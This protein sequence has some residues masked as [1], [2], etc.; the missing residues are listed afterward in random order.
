MTDLYSVVA[1]APKIHLHCHLEGS[2][3]CSSSIPLSALDGRHAF[4]QRFGRNCFSLDSRQAFVNLAENFVSVAKVQ[5][6]RYGEI[7]IAPGVWAQLHPHLDVLDVIGAINQV[8]E[9]GAPD[10]VLRL[11]V[12][13]SRNLDVA[14]AM[15]SASIAVSARDRGVIGIGLG[16]AEVNA[17]VRRFRDTFSFA[18]KH[19]LHTVAHAGEHG[20]AESVKQAVLQ[21]GAER[22]GHA[23]SAIKDM[24]VVRLLRSRG[25]VVECCPTSNYLTQALP[26][27]EVHP[28][29]RLDQLGVRVVIDVDDPE[30]FGQTITDEYFS[31]ASS[32]GWEIMSRLIGNA[33]DGSFAPS[34]TKAKLW[35]ELKAYQD[36]V[37]GASTD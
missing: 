6:V 27:C 29:R 32:C 8:F 21:L 15:W 9:T 26:F 23:V 7:F 34:K 36:F 37:S 20:S 31:I 5:R 2:L 18:R 14:N 12:G 13:I 1:N 28:W 24:D 33:I 10:T 30:I 17:D 4:A 19:D 35:L 25:T 3:P 22:I 11:I 16:G